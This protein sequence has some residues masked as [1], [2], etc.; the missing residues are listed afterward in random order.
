[1]SLVRAALGLILVPATLVVLAPTPCA[2]AAES[3]PARHHFT[4]GLGYGQHTAEQFE[5]DNLKSGIQGQF[6]Y[7]YS[8]TP[9]LDLTFDGRSLTASDEFE[10][11][12]GDTWTYSHTAA[13]FG[14]G[15]RYGGTT[16]NVRPYMQANVFFAKETVRLESG[17]FGSDASESGAGFGLAGGADIRLSNL[18]SMPIEANFL[19]AKPEN[20]VSSLGIQAGLTFNFGMMP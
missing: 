19:Y 8:V 4:L 2:L 20:D 18:L 10:D 5:V 14:P 6:G 13:Y 1:M 12:N 11:T 17:D 3:T 9:K 16:G 7:R 15:V